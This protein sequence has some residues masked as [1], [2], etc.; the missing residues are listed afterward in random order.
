MPPTQD[1][2]STVPQLTA[3]DV[4]LL[5]TAFQSLKDEGAI[6]IDYAKLAELA[7]YKTAASANASFL[8]LKKK[9]KSGATVASATAATPSKNSK[10]NKSKPAV[11]GDAEDDDE[12]TPTKAAPKKRSKAIKIEPTDAEGGDADTEV[13]PSADSPKKDCGKKATGPAH[14]EANADAVTET[15]NPT[16]KRK[17]GPNKPKDPN[18][19]PSKRAK[20]AG[21]AVATE[22]AANA[23]LHD[24]AAAAQMNGE[25]S[26]FGGDSNIKDEEE[27]EEKE[28][29]DDSPID[30]EEQKMADDALFNTYLTEGQEA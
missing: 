15:T 30:V 9:L 28:E 21:V 7:G 8:V 2:T 1:N 10:R 11:N 18:A 26:I 14:T 20:K 16:P 23:Q 17:R 13:T 6:Q 29:V 12:A 3:R 5:A 19:H 27:E 4:S 22:D 24:D 25:Q